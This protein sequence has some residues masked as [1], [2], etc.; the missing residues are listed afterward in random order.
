MFGAA[1]VVVVV[2]V[3][4]VVVD[5]VVVVVVVVVVVIIVVVVVVVGV[6]VG[7]CGGGDVVVSDV[8][9]VLFVCLVFLL[10]S[11]DDYADDGLGQQVETCFKRPVQH[12]CATLLF[13]WEATEFALA[14]LRDQMQIQGC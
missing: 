2:V 9:C 10:T 12:C 4:A 3:V 8:R 5:L 14:C 11:H 13:H 6:V 7:G 1:V